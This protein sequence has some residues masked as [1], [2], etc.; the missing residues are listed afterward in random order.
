[1]STNQFLKWKMSKRKCPLSL[2]AGSVKEEAGSQ[3]NAKGG[4]R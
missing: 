3:I 4:L 2:M 1:M